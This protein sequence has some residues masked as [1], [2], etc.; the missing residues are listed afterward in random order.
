L[1]AFQA[2]PA[3]GVKGALSV[4]IPARDEAANIKACVAATL[5]A[6]DGVEV[7]VVA[8]DDASED[9]TAAIVERLA[10]GDP[11]VRLVRGK[12]LPAG[13]NGKQHA[14]QQ[15]ADA[16][17]HETVLWIDADVR[18]APGALGR[19]LAEQERS[20]VALV[21]GFPRQVTGSPLE[22]MLL[23]L[24]HFVLLGFLSLRAMRGSLSPALAAGCGQLFL[25]QRES[26]RCAGGHAA[27]RASRHD[28]ITLPRAYRRAGLN[29]DVFDATDV[30][31]CRMYAGAA[32][33][34]RGLVKNATEGVAKLPLLLPVTAILLLGQVVWLPLLAAPGS[35]RWIAA[36]AGCLSMAPRLHAAW[37]YRQPIYGALLHPL[38]LLLFLVIQWEALAR[39]WLGRPV[40]WKGRGAA[41]ESGP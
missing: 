29:T 19:L 35:T 28:G 39:D 4:L 13:W 25:T 41:V 26:Y 38:G 20:G 23:P 2:A 3:D 15:L 9:D 37:R 40:A 1:T 31:S 32:A 6:A 5:A 8:L 14:C 18:L 27:I 34:W 11:R 17:T 10:A 30:A 36:L 12:P 21:S 22:A 16:A 24:I 33:T 7:E